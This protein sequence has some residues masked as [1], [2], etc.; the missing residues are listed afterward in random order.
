[1]ACARVHFALTAIHIQIE[2]ILNSYE[3]EDLINSGKINRKLNGDLNQAV[4]KYLGIWPINNHLEIQV[5]TVCK[6]NAKEAPSSW[7]QPFLL[8]LLLQAFVPNQRWVEIKVAAKPM[9]VVAGEVFPMVMMLEL[10]PT[11]RAQRYRCG[12]LRNVIRSDVLAAA[13]CAPG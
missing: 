11:T 7:D 1:M 6:Q 5:A 4:R 10:A 12:T 9:A 13:W 8:L 3:S 2:L